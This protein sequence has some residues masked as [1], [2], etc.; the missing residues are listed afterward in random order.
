M[1]IVESTSRASRRP[2]LRVASAT[3]DRLRITADDV[4][5][6]LIVVVVV[7]VEVG[8]ASTRRLGLGAEHESRRVGARQGAARD[9]DGEDGLWNG[10]KE[11]WI[12]DSE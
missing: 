10:V 6:W 1:A 11:F 3:T 8:V 7:V 12:H 9:A 5:A 2:S 4:N